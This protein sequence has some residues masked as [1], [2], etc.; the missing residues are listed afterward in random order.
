MYLSSVALLLCDVSY[1]QNMTLLARDYTQ[2]QR[3]T[4][5]L[6]F[7]DLI[8]DERTGIVLESMNVMSHDGVI[9]SFINKVALLAIKYCTLWLV[10]DTE[11]SN[12]E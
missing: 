1:R 4:G 6:T 7:A 9:D 10:L 12:T 2:L 5:S 11:G 3:T 8:I